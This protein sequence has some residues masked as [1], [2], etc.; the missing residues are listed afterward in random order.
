[1]K[2]FISI[3]TIG[4]A[5]VLS[6]SCKDYFN[7][8]RENQSPWQ[9]ASEL[10]MAARAPYLY[11]VGAAW[12]NPIGM[13][14]LRGFAESD[15]S[16]YTGKTGDS[17]YYAYDA[18]SWKTL[19]LEN[20]KELEGGFEYLYYMSTACN[21][22]LKMLR[23]AEEAG[24]DPFLDMTDADRALVKR[25]KGELLFMR[26][27]TYW[28][29]ARTWAPP[30]D[31]NGTNSTKHF[32][33]Y[34]DYVTEA[35]KLKDAKLA[36]VEE[37][38]DAIVK[39][40]KDAIAILPE[41]Y[42]SG[43]N[44]NRMRVNKYC[45]EALLAR[46]YFYMGKFSDAKPLIDDVID[47]K[48]LYDLDNEPIDSFNKQ[49]GWGTSK[50]VIWEIVYNAYSERYDR[51]PGIMNYCAYNGH[52][53]KQS[54]Y[55]AFVMSYHAME[56]VGWMTPTTHE[57]T[58]LAKS[59]KRYQKLYK[60]SNTEKYNNKPYIF[61]FK[62]FRASDTDNNV[63]RRANRPMIRLADLYLMRAEI[64]WLNKDYTAATDDVNAVRVRAGLSPLSTLDGTAG[65]TGEQAIENE[66][67]IE[68]GGENA[69][70]IFWLIALHKDIPIGDRD[71]SKFQ[72][73][74]YPY[75]DYYYQIPVLEQ[76]TNLAYQKND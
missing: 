56:Q 74:K 76:Q 8:E 3:L 75:S 63:S 29:L 33:V 46:V 65:V 19:I 9:S 10:E 26:A 44:N 64:N 55:C 73:I 28:N 36:T 6:S 5:L 7:L 61:L 62:Y 12:Q 68:C 22:P 54:T 30:Y 4:L 18:R 58:E 31:I 41:E 51:N 52:A 38:Y 72:P 47:Q 11:Y 49:S 2:K 15:I 35:D 57:V 13:L 53:T 20:A 16:Q 32:V 39:D 17:Y 71:P 69:D 70:R 45:A 43:D 59:D 14:P 21:A 40:L 50:E 23:E 60:Y 67:I 25:I 48:S 1:M 37:V 34:K 24:R 42:Y 27:F 66:R